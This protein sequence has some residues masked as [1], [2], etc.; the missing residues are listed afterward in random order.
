VSTGAIVGIVIACGVVVGV[1]VRVSAMVSDQHIFI[2]AGLRPGLAG[3]SPSAVCLIELFVLHS[4]FFD[5]AKIF[6]PEFHNVC[7]Q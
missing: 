6:I 2:N 5:P 1:V 3:A 7:S 4:D